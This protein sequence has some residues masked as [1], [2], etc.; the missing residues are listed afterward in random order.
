MR[1]VLALAFVLVG[2]RGATPETQYQEALPT[3]SDLLPQSFQLTAPIGKSDRNFFVA[4]P[5]LESSDSAPDGGE[6]AGEWPAPELLIGAFDAGADAANSLDSLCN[7]L[8]TSAQ[9]NGLPIPF[10]ANLI[11]QESHLERDAIS[12]A[13]ALGIAQFM[14]DT[15][16]EV[17]LLHPFD[18]RQA[19]PASA[20]LLRVLREHFGNLGFVAAAYNAGARRV[21]EWIDHHGSLP[22]QTRDYVLHVTG[23]SL[24]TWRKAPLDDSE[25]AFVQ[26]LP[27]RDLPA[28]AELEQVQS[29]AAQ[30]IEET[31]QLQMQQQKVAAAAA[32]PGKPTAQKTA[33]AEP[34][35]RRRNARPA[36]AAKDT[37][38]AARK[39]RHSREATHRQHAPHEKRR[40]A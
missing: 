20:R 6:D 7:A 33:K 31:H 34:T 15:A 22:L 5:A 1:A 29:Q 12:R 13:G 3:I 9:D 17:G 23:H 28:F 24:E 10:F 30:Q 2:L 36:P 37:T 16:A 32:G 40:V 19:I 26:P 27:C 35:A 21:G 38:V 11:W 25:L 14:P 4:T 39:V 8:L 18:P